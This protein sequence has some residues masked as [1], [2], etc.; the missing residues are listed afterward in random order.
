M[1]C[2]EFSVTRSIVLEVSE[3]IFQDD[4]GISLKYFDESIWALQLYGEYTWP[5]KDF[6]PYTHQP[7]LMKRYQETEAA[8][9]KH[10][11]FPMGYHYWGDQKQNHIIATRKY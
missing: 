2:R 8:L 7:D 1:C 3:T 11:P 4:T 9:I 5:I 6:A 10:L